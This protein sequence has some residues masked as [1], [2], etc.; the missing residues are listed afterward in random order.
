MNLKTHRYAWT[1]LRGALIAVKDQSSFF[2]RCNTT[3]QFKQLEWATGQIRALRNEVA[4]V[5]EVAIEVG[6]PIY[7]ISFDELYD[8]TKGSLI[9][10]HPGE[11]DL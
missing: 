1:N 8:Y 9:D 5:L 7:E 2:G 6:K 3:D 11:D 10:A 4:R